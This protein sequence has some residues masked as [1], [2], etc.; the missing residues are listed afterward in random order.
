MGGGGERFTRGAAQEHE[1][2]H[3][4]NMGATL[5]IVWNVRGLKPPGAKN[6]RQNKPD[7]HQDEVDDPLGSRHSG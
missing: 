7:H 2:E 6:P 4:E 3:I 1:Q 5:K